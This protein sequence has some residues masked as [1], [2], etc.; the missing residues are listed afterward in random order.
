MQHM[1]EDKAKRAL[2]AGLLTVLSLG[3]GLLSTPAQAVTNGQLV[4]DPKSS[5]PY[6]V[7]IWTTTDSNDYK[8]AEF[9]CTGTLIGPQVV[10]TAAHCTTYTTPYFVKVGADS[11]N[12]QT[13]FTQV[14]AI[15][16]SP[17]YNPKTFTND[18]G[19]LKL[20]D[21]LK[22]LSFQHLPVLK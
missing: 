16:T 21:R 5:A 13:P 22:I 11:L 20:T 2:F 6:V 15:W 7:S 4:P 12:D 14:S 3:L 9:L 8:D 1:R 10:L 17:R 19:L 18:V